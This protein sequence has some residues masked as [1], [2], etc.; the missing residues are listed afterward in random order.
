MDKAA[1]PVSDTAR[2]GFK[3]AVRVGLNRPE[4]VDDA[5]EMIGAAG[6]SEPSVAWINGSPAAFDDAVAEAERLLRASALPVFAHLGAD[7]EGTREAVLLAEL[8]G[9]VLDHAASAALLGDLDPIRETGGMLT[10][11]LEAA[12]RADVALLVGAVA[13]PD[14]LD[15]PAHPFDSD[16]ARRAI[17]LGASLTPTGVGNIET[18]EGAALLSFL[19][20][21]RA[22]IKRRP[23][24]SAPTGLEELAETLRGAR[25]GVA[26]WDAADLDPLA[27]EAI[28]GLVRDLNE[29][30]RFSTLS[31]PA[32]DNGLC[33]QT[34]CGWM[35]GFPL[36]TGFFGNRPQHDPW[37]HDSRRLLASGETDCVIWV[38]ALAGGAV[39]SEAADIALCAADSPVTA[40][41]RFTIATPG[42]D[43]DAIL[44]D[45]GAGALVARKANAASQAPTAAAT[46][47]AIRARLER[48]PC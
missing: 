37:R 39:P 26:I 17:R 13:A 9:G 38:S 5:E 20:A 30:M 32:R 16:I 27:I 2:R 47:A 42:V 33:V 4:V 1:E 7:V 34:V 36:R 6:D 25:F 11:P 40:R 31:A 29:T 41:V 24:A 45:D 23:L 10:T 18:G 14:W 3:G 43:C 22:R 46:L 15:R 12:V 28:H 21:L 19:A 48:P 35:T 8:I 44:H